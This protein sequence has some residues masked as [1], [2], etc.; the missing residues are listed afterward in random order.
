MTN[1]VVYVV[2]VISDR[3]KHLSLSLCLCLRVCVLAHKQTN[4]QT[5]IIGGRRAMRKTGATAVLHTETQKGA[6]AKI[7]RASEGERREGENQRHVFRKS[8]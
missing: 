5:K 1:V 8:D 7:V 2:Y 4:K 3:V 6:N